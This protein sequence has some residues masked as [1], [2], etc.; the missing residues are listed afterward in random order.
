[1]LRDNQWER[2]ARPIIGRADQ[3]DSTGRDNRMF[4]ESVPWIVRTG[5]PW[6]D[7]PDAF[8]ARNSVFRRFSRWSEKD[9]WGHLLRDLE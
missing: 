5:S 1:M 2:M 6:R 4:R 9:V 8:G 7:P 3:K